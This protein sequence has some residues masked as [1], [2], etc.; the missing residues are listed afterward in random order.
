MVSILNVKSPCTVSTS[1]CLLST[2]L[3]DGHLII[4]TD[5][6][7][8]LYVM[9]FVYLFLL[10]LEIKFEINTPDPENCQV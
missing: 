8:Q 3:I 9:I 10:L 4:C 6:I 7:Y 1:L 5:N 2:V